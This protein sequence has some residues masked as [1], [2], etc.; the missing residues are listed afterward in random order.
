MS[1]EEKPRSRMDE[2]KISGGGG[3]GWGLVK[4]STKEVSHFSQQNKC[5][6]YWNDVF[7]DIISQ[8]QHAFMIMKMAPENNSMEIAWEGKVGAIKYSNV[9][10]EESKE[11]A[12]EKKTTNNTVD[13]H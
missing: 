10:L 3:G 6:F 4:V 8:C 11:L 7:C 12:R 5:C 2:C 13:I 1:R 9:T